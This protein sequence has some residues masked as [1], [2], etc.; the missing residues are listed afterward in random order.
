[1]GM[2]DRRFFSFAC[3]A[4]LSGAL[5]GA[6]PAFGA[7]A[8]AT[9]GSGFSGTLSSNP[10]VRRQQLI[11]DPT[12][13][14]SGST[15][16][17]YNPAVAT[18]A[19]QQSANF[20]FGPGY[21]QTPGQPIA[22]V[23]YQQSAFKL[24]LDVNS[25]PFTLPSG[26]AETG[27]VQVLFSKNGQPTGRLSPSGPS[28]DFVQVARD[29]GVTGTSGVD[30]FALIFQTPS[31]STPLTSTATYQIFAASSGSHG[32]GFG[33][34]GNAGDYMAGLTDTGTP[35]RVPVNET[36]P[37]NNPNDPTNYIAPAT[38][39]GNYIPEPSTAAAWGVAAGL[40]L[41]RR[42]AR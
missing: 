6:A 5:A 16:V 26:G 41:R 21:G 31:T 42:H 19:G 36:T 10:T 27:Y 29:P 38:V 35:F 14:T 12:D 34:P 18:L 1:M 17:S 33:G 30:T 28:G 25:F 11:C 3:A 40:L 4:G 37:P 9:G 20:L 23:E 39:S 32:T 8:Q 22:R 24:F 15:S 13:P 7:V 2:R